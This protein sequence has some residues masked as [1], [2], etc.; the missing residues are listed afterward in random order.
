MS[1]SSS[2]RSSS[3]HLSFLGTV[4]RS[5]RGWNTQLGLTHSRVSG[6]DVPARAHN[7]R[8]LTE[9]KEVSGGVPTGVRGGRL[10]TEG[11]EVSSGGGSLLAEGREVSGGGGRLLAEGREVG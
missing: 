10:L 6:G 8:L 4:R 2:L 7:R 3:P 5:C 11:R 9:G 1:F